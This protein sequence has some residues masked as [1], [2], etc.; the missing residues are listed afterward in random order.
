M[1]LKNINLYVKYYLSKI[2]V[3]LSLNEFETIDL[4]TNYSNL[5]KYYYTGVISWPEVRRQY[6]QLKIK[7]LQSMQK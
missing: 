3:C 2:G 7:S 4:Y 6:Y 1:K 5:L